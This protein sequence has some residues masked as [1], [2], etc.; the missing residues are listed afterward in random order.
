M[1]DEQVEQ[2]TNEIYNFFNRFV[3]WETAIVRSS[4]LTISENHAIE[5]LGIYGKMNM[6]TLADKLAVTRGTVTVTVDRLEKG[7]YAKRSTIEEDRRAYIIEL[8]PEGHEAF[9]EHHKH[10]LRLTEELAPLLS[11]TETETLIRI[12]Q[13]L[14]ADL[15]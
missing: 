13:R 10:H 6:K 15:F 11:D 1:S 5:V 3:S 8:T 14:N 4:D 2:L 7:G 12:L 9:E